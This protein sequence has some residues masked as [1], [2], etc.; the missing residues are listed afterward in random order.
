[1]AGLYIYVIFGVFPSAIIP[2]GTLKTDEPVP[3]KVNEPVAILAFPFG[4]LKQVPVPFIEAAFILAVPF[5]TLKAFEPV[6]AIEILEAVPITLIAP[7]VV[8]PQN[9]VLVDG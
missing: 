6:P 4:T 2:F 5:G 7:L 9:N 8:P 1:M 3:A